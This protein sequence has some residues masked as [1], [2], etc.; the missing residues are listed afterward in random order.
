MLEEEVEF[1]GVTIGATM[2]QPLRLE[3]RGAIPA[4]LFVDLER[5]PEFTVEMDPKQIK[6]RMPVIRQLVK[7]AT[8]NDSGS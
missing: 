5:H 2:R 1:G 7:S 8:W 6:P 3:N 4:V